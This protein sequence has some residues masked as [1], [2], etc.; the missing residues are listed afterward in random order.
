MKYIVSLFRKNYVLI[1]F[2]PIILNAVL[3]FLDPNSFNNFLQTKNLVLF[4]SFTLGSFFYFYL[5]R[6][7]KTFLKLDSFSLSLSMFLV[8]FFVFESLFLFI[9]KNLSF[10]TSI[11]I[12]S[13]IWF[14][15]ILFKRKNYLEIFKLTSIYII[16]RFFNHFF[17]NTL[18]DLS[19]YVE[20]NSDVPAQW[21]GIVEMI[22]NKNYF[23]AFENNLIEGQGLLPSY[24]QALMLKI[25][26]GLENFTFIPVTIN[27]LLFFSILLIV[28]LPLNLNNKVVLIITFV[29]LILNNNWLKYLMINSLMIEG[30]VSFLFGVFLYNLKDNLYSKKFSSLLFFLFFGSLTL[31]KNFV[32]LLSMGTVVICLLFLKKNKYVLLGPGVYALYLIYQKI[33]LPNIQNVAYTSEID[34]KDLFFDFIFLRD[35]NL[36]NISNIFKHFTTDIPS[37]YLIFLFLIFNIFNFLVMNK[38]EFTQTFMFVFVVVNFLLVNLLYVSYWRNVEYESSYRYIMNCFHL[39]FIS[40]GLSISNFVNR[41]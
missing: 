30:I 31:T 20:L 40:T 11:A 34:F 38:F 33:Y 1:L 25:G 18:K 10:D 5:S 16:W 7:I 24:I 17:L 23:Y 3:N 8:S 14:S 32:S 15:V 12:V 36:S 26:F 27:L 35:L 2:S 13:T 39:I 29:F 9:T 37:T 21:I 6:M 28:D 41:K 19:N 4:I 22:Y